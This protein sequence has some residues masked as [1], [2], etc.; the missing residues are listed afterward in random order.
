V[1]PVVSGADGVKT[2]VR[3]L[4]TYVTT[5]TGL[6]HGVGQVTKKFVVV[7]VAGA[8]SS[9][10]IALIAELLGTPVVGPGIVVI[11]AVAVTVGRVVSEVRPVVK[12]HT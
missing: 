5:P 1:A 12:V 4:V 6:M 8:T 2:A 3:L 7:I 11:G 9:L 10:K